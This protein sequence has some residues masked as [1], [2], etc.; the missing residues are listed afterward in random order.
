MLLIFC[1]SLNF[2]VFS[3]FFVPLLSFGFTVTVQLQCTHHISFNFWSLLANK[4]IKKSCLFFKYILI[5]TLI[6]CGEK[7]VFKMHAN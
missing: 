5:Y 3:L 1:I 2:F 7:I 4:S 6:T